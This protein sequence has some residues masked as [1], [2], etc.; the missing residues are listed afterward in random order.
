MSWFELEIFGILSSYGNHVY[1]LY[2][3]LGPDGA[4]GHAFPDYHASTGI[5]LFYW[6]TYRISYIIRKTKSPS[7]EHISTV[8]ALLNTLLLIGPY[9]TAS[10][11]AFWA[12]LIIGALEFICVVPLTKRRREA[13]IVL[14]WALPPYS[15]PSLPLFRQQRCHPVAGWR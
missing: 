15:A 14:T 1:W 13:F 5:L 3:L 2:R 10:Q 4:Q 8:A 11:L 9:P 12:L 7:E 6:I